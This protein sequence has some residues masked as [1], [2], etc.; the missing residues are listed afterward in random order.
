[1]FLGGTGWAFAAGLGAATGV[2]V[3]EK[4]AWAMAKKV[5]T[6]P[7]ATTKAA[8]KAQLLAGPGRLD[9]GEKGAMLVKE[10]VV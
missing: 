4:S 3:E 9:D 6:T 7:A 8:V 10:A 2:G 1:M 5:K